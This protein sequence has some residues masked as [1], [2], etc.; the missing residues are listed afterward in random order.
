MNVRYASSLVED[1]VQLGRQRGRRRVSYR[2]LLFL[3]PLLTGLAMILGASAPAK[4]PSKSAPTETMV[5]GRDALPSAPVSEPLLTLKAE[6]IPL[7]KS[8][9]ERQGQLDERDKQFAQREKQLASREADLL[10]VQQHIEEK[11]TALAMLRKEMGDL[12]QEKA[13]FE[14]KRFEHLV[15]MYEVMK[16]EEISALF[17]RLNEDTAARLLYQMKE[18]K[19][20]QILASI[21]PQ[22][23]A[24]LSERLAAQRQQEMQHTPA[25][26]KP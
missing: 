23:A 3:V 6:D 22:V 17:E 11:L 20:G 2:A 8:L 21:S 1:T 13:A 26:E 16:P 25:K 15:K 5:P 7:L 24:K 19:A 10:L 18:K 14:E 4:T 12:L 9:R